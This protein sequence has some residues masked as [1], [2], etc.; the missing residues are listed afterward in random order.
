MFRITLYR[1]DFA[2]PRKSC[3]KG[4]FPSTSPRGAYIWRGDFTE[5]FFAL[6]VW[7]AYIWRG[8]FSE[9]YGN[10]LRHLSKSRSSSSSFSSSLSSSDCNASSRFLFCCSRFCSLLSHPSLRLVFLTDDSG[11]CSSWVH[12][13]EP[14]EMSSSSSSAAGCS[15]WTGLTGFGV[16]GSVCWAVVLVDF[17]GRPRAFFGFLA[18]LLSHSPSLLSLPENSK[19]KKWD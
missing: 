10:R 18:C 15:C 19:H 9:F 6:R 1:I 5:G 16:D 8:L 3:Q 11:A 14:E 17:G 12:S 2:P 4:Q 13:P 7:G